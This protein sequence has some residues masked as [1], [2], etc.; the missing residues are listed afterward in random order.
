MKTSLFLIFAMSALLVL[1]GCPESDAWTSEQ[2]GVHDA[3]LAWSKAVSNQNADAMWEMLSPDAQEFYKREL[4]GEGGVRQ[5][6][7]MNR[8]ALK[9]EARTPE[10]ERERIRKLLGALPDNPDNLTPQAYY[11]WRV[12]PELTQEGASRTSGLFERSN[13]STISVQGD[14]ATAVLKNGNP[15]RYSWVRHDGVWKFDLHPSILRALEETRKRENE[16]N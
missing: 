15:D 14:S 5:A 9:P 4:E 2:Q 3:M 10:S 12:T 1:P 8:A 13:V 11:G 16:P 7:K 6:V